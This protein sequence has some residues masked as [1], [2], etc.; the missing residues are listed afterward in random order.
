MCQAQFACLLILSLSS[1]L[2]ECIV[3]L[4]LLIFP[5]VNTLTFPL[6]FN[7]LRHS[8]TASLS[9]SLLSFSYFRI[10][11]LVCS[12]W[13][14]TS[15]TVTLFV[16]DV[17]KWHQLTFL[18]CVFYWTWSCDDKGC[19]YSLGQSFCV[20]LSIYLSL[21]RRLPSRHDLLGNRRKGNFFV[22]V[23]ERQKY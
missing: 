19:H 20:F 21:S 7:L 6:I 13:D 3:L 14:C 9:L 8:L 5:F 18:C 15:F 1:N 17:M 10:T 12:L 11:S 23:Q 4:L 22:R 2:S 16:A